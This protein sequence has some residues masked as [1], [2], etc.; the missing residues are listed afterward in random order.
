MIFEYGNAEVER[1]S[2]CHTQRDAVKTRV[3]ETAKRHLNLL[4]SLFGEA[5]ESSATFGLTMFGIYI[6]ESYRGILTYC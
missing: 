2:F 5:A 1:S 3:I 6:C 4:I